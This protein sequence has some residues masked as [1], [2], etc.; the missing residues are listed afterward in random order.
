[1]YLSDYIVFD[2]ETT[3]FSRERDSII[4]LAAVKVRNHKIVDTFSEL[5]NP[6]IPLPDNIVEITHITDDMLKNAPQIK[7]VMKK[8][9]DFIGNDPLVGHNIISFDMKF[10]SRHALRYCT[11]RIG[12]KQVD[13]LLLA[14]QYL[15]GGHKLGEVAAHYGHS[16]E[17][18]HRALNDVMMNQKV[19][20]D[21]CKEFIAKPN[22]NEKNSGQ[23][24]L[25]DMM[26]SVPVKT[27]NKFYCLVAGSRGF[28][29]YGLLCQK[30]DKI[31]K[32]QKDVVIVSGGATGADRL[33]ERYAKDRG[34]E[35]IVIKPDWDKY[36]KKAGYIRNEQMHKLIASHDNRGCVC[37]WDGESHGTRDNFDRCKKYNTPLRVI[38]YP[39]ILEEYR[40]KEDMERE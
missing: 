11:H 32:N 3:G 27:D 26:D 8:F 18:A 21:L 34:Y 31:L 38:D 24:S 5:I 2:I 28:E 7:P 12:N 16:A 13:T 1:M 36:G 25:F 29:H 35:L 23:I 6:N 10:I 39:K 19:Y 17:G 40:Q 37:F 20:E 9:I 4:E 14:R 30:M 15:K 33:A 22:K